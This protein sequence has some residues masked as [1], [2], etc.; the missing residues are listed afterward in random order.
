MFAPR[1]RFASYLVLLFAATGAF[2]QY[3][4]PVLDG[5]TT[6]EYAYSSGDWS[7]TWDATYLYI[8]KANVAN[9][10][11]IAVYVDIDPRSTPRSGTA[12]NGNVV[13]NSDKWGAATNGFA[14]GLPFR[15]DA[16]SLTGNGFADLR[17]RDGSGGWTNVTTSATD[18]S[19][20]AT[21]ST[22]EIR[23]RWAAMPGLT[24]PPAAFNWYGYELEPGPADQ[25]FEK[26][27]S[28]AGNPS[29][30]ISAPLLPYF[31]SVS[32]T[33]NGAASNPF[34]TQQSTWLVTSSADSGGST[35]RQAVTDA[36]GDSVSVRR[37]IVFDTIADI[38]LASS[39][40]PMTRATT[41][42]GST[43]SG[44]VAAPLVN[45][46]PSAGVVAD[47]FTFSGSAAAQV[48]GLHLSGFDHAISAA[49]SPALHIGTLQGRNDLNGNATAIAVNNP[50]GLV[51]EGNSIYQNASG[52]AITNIMQTA[53]LVNTAVIDT[54]NNLQLQFS[55]TSDSVSAATL[56]YR[57]DL[58]D[59]DPANYG[60]PQPKTF[61]ARSA[62]YA[63]SSLTNTA[64]QVGTGY[65]AADHL[66]AMITSFSDAACGTAGDGTSQP[67]AVFSPHAVAITST[68]V[69]GPSSGWS[70]AIAT[71]TA[72]ISNAY[73]SPTGTVS[74]NDNGN[75]IAGCT[76]L[77]IA[78]GN[79]VPCSVTLSSSGAHGITATYSG[80]IN[81]N[82]STSAAFTDTI[83]THTFTG[84]GNFTDT[85]RWSSATVPAAGEDFIIAGAC[86]IDS[87]LGSVYGNA[88]V[89]AGG[90]IGMGTS[91]STLKV[92][93]LDGASS[94]TVD[95]TNGGF[96]GLYGN[97]NTSGLTFTAGVGEVDYYGTSETLPALDFHALHMKA[98]S[99]VTAINGKATVSSEFAVVEATFTPSSGTIE[100]RGTSVLFFFVSTIS[101]PNLTIASGASV[102][103]STSAAFNA[104]TFTVDGTFTPDAN[105]VISGTLT[106]SG[107][108]V[109]NRTLSGHAF[110]D[111]YSGSKVLSNLTVEFAGTSQQLW[112]QI[113]FLSYHSVIINNA[114]GVNTSSITLDATGTLTLAAGVVDASG[115]IRINNPSPSAVLSTGGWIA[116]HGLDRVI[117]TGTNVYSYPV[118]TTTAA[119]PITVM[120]TNSNAGITSL[121]A[122]LTPGEH[123]QL[124]A[125][126]LNAAHDLNVYA[127]LYTNRAITADFTMTYSGLTDSGA[128]PAS[129]AMRMYNTMTSTWTNIPA[130]PA[131]AS[132]S[133]Y[134]VSLPADQTTNVTVGNLLIDH[135]DLSATS[136]QALGTAFLTTVT[137]RDKFGVAVSDDSSTPVTMSSNSAIFDANGDGTFGDRAKTLSGGALTISTKVASGGGLV[138][139]SA[140]DG[141]GHT[142]S[143]T[144]TIPA[145][146]STALLSSAPSSAYGQ[147]VT[148]TATVTSSGNGTISGSVTF[149]DGATTLGSGTISGGVATFST[150]AVTQG[151]HSITATYN[152]D[153]TF[154]SS[155]SS[156]VT[157]TVTLGTP[158]SLVA[159]AGSTSQV[160]VSWTGVTGATSYL[161]YRNNTLLT[162]TAST[163]LNDTTV[164]A[165]SAYVYKVQASNSSG[166]SALSAPDLATTI[167]FTDSSLLGN[168]IKAVHFEQLR[169]AVNAV[170]AAAGLSAA[171]FTDPTPLAGVVIK[172]VHLTEL[173]TALDAA[174]T[175]LGLPT[176]TYTEPSV[177]VQA[178]QVTEL[179]AG[180]Q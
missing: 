71:F 155:T 25:M 105:A 121:S 106:G 103:M 143:T 104:D 70:G 95:M 22:H 27:P 147:S 164:S 145:A 126:G 30:V 140:T 2:A 107:K 8:A 160:T 42:D 94:W 163:S 17:T 162:S 159:T 169:T 115:D 29:D 49:A 116:T 148:F 101:I 166:T 40:P 173:R 3:Q 18:V 146:T 47:G 34:E 51:I 124:A 55:A 61:R 11:G 136:P 5:D 176:L 153:S 141:N 66:V 83:S 68:V 96:L 36:E 67:S 135:Y 84:T 92:H 53:P 100:M 125:S 63:G 123:P 45:V 56:S 111:Q 129:F 110:T 50:G 46:S 62:C 38:A 171:T 150:S 133:A 44:F 98:G 41:I 137:A 108:V 91:G 12:A 178:V 113:G 82:G 52:I 128:V 167:V 26:N 120:T 144:V 77:T 64:W 73:G 54:G 149:K 65:S 99:T 87:A 43:Q 81:N 33:A 10:R 86:T 122:S 35:L 89:N 24:G 37:Y 117:A 28:P 59:A 1:L 23:I 161:L 79:Q 69:S 119:A 78:G 127:R 72:T 58:Y 174:R 130:F 31:F 74:F 19:T 165:N 154:L 138:T 90:S 157:Q 132:I 85:A 60:N 109:V 158:T 152:G 142:G 57:L 39:L 151:S 172:H 93:D 9:G 75:A 21:G 13:S 14:S 97:W 168:T 177:I 16:R 102:S 20:F 118:G 32:S 4:T 48:L 7:M 156:A 15:A 131:A 88:H 76:A 134:G 175:A 112:S 6:G 139:L 170:R 179:R 80:D 114:A 180:T